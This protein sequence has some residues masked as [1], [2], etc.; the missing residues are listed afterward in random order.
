MDRAARECLPARRRRK[1]HVVKGRIRGGGVT[2]GRSGDKQLG[3][4]GRMDVFYGVG[5]G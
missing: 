3:K 4:G 1:E 5:G 2:Q